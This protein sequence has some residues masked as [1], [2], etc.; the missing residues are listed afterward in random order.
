MMRAVSQ[1]Q[2]WL[3]D[4]KALHRC[5]LFETPL[6][7]LIFLENRSIVGRQCVTK[8]KQSGD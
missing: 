5:R 7:G 8:E 1:N 6:C 3:L 2:A 4:L